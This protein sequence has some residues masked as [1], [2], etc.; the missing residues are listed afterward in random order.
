VNRFFAIPLA[1]KEKLSV[2]LFICHA[3]D[4]QKTGA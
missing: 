4:L 1:G 2:K 3:A